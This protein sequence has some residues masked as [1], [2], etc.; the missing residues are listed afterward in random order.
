[1]TYILYIMNKFYSVPIDR[2]LA[3]A[4][5]ILVKY[6]GRIPVILE[7]HNRSKLPP[8]EQKKFLLPADITMRDFQKILIQR[9][10]VEPTTSIYLFA[11]QCDKKEKKTHALLSG[12]QT[13]ADVYQDWKND[14]KFLYIYY[15]TEDTFG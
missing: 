11:E 5:R 15:N 2:R 13:A 6:P 9:L 7:C 14:D 4:E 8:L 12:S 1:M 3:E 10:K